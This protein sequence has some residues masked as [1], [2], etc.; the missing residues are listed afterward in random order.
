MSQTA[1]RESELTF[2]YTAAFPSPFNWI[3]MEF[4]Q[5][6]D[7]YAAAAHIRDASAALDSGWAAWH[8]QTIGSFAGLEISGGD[9]TGVLIKPGC[10]TRKGH[11]QR[12]HRAESATQ[13]AISPG[14]KAEEQTQHLKC[15]HLLIAAN[16][17]PSQLPKMP[18]WSISEKS[19][20]SGLT[21]SETEDFQSHTLDT[22]AAAAGFTAPP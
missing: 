6:A 18:E 15:F 11:Q 4:F 10:H 12:L 8:S 3:Y 20:T 9:I 13:V 1:V 2:E 5:R 19:S 22:V 14:E 21:H 17:L 16:D 7:R